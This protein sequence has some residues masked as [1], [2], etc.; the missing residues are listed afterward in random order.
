MS[1]GIRKLLVFCSVDRIILADVHIIQIFRDIQV[2]TIRDIGKRLIL[3]RCK[4]YCLAVNLCFLIS[5]LRPLACND[6]ACLAVLHQ[7]HRDH[8]ELL[9]CSA[10]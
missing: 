1:L 8:G 9:G 5:F 3:G 7:V 10:L 6:I 4:L 2:G